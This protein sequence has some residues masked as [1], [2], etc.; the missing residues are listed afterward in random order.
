MGD[1]KR[2]RKSYSRPKSPWRSDQ[3][4]QELYLVGTNGLRNKRELWK[5]QTKLSAVRKQARRLL[6]ASTEV[7][8]REEKKLLDSL[9]RS[10][11][12][13]EGS[14]LDDVLGLSIEDAL[15][16]RLQSVVFK[17]G[18]ATSPQHARQLVTHKHVM[19]GERVIDIP[20]YRVTKSEEGKIHITGLRQPAEP[21]QEAPPA[22]QG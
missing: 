1:P 12:L 21:K 5:T 13:G 6:A 17:Q 10:G 9:T 8:Q 14:T 15:G 3:L 11:L 18:L 20:G 7:R 16:R 19:I 4:A 22:V 2:P